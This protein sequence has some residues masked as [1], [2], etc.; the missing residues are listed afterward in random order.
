MAPSDGWFKPFE[1]HETHVDW[2]ALGRMILTE[3]ISLKLAS[4]GI[5]LGMRGGESTFGETKMERVGST[6]LDRI[7]QTMILFAAGR[8]EA[9]KRF[10]VEDGA[11][12]DQRFWRLAQALS[13]LYPASTEEKRWVD[14]VLARKKGLGF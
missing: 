1:V 7:H 8:G 12:N 14:G 11:G 10:L 5:G 2:V 13:A 3:H 9:L 6:V 4:T